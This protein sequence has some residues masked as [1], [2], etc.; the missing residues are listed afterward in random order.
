MEAAA[1][2]MYENEWVGAWCARGRHLSTVAVFDER[3]RSRDISF[4]LPWSGCPLLTQRV[5]TSFLRVGVGLL[6]GCIMQGWRGDLWCC[7]CRVSVRV[8][9]GWFGFSSKPSKV[10]LRTKTARPLNASSYRHR[11]FC[12]RC[13]SAFLTKFGYCRLFCA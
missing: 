2:C 3:A 5:T 13:E 12:P 9:L 6:C 4:L 7:A 8:Y 10:D 1:S 11:S